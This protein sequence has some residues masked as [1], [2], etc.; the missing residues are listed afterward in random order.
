MFD[1]TNNIGIWLS[2]EDKQLYELQIGSKTSVGYK[3]NRKVKLRPSK[4]KLMEVFDTDINNLEIA[5]S[6]TPQKKKNDISFDKITVL[7]IKLQKLVGNTRNRYSS[8]SCQKYQIKL[9]KNSCSSQGKFK[10]RF[11]YSNSD[12]AGY[13]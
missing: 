5:T 13:P 10:C 9:Q 8:K 3:T 7:Q 12:S 11:G 2:Q 6:Y 1:I 4:Q